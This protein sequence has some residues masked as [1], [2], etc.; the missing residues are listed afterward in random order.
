[1]TEQAGDGSVALKPLILV[2][3]V[4]TLA[5]TLLRL[6]GEVLEWSPQF[7]SREAGGAMAIVGIVWLVP[8]FGA[9]F[10]VKLVQMGHGPSGIGRVFGWAVLGLL[11]F[12]GAGFLGRILPFAQGGRRFILLF[13]VGSIA[14]VW[15]AFRG[16]PALGR[17]LVAYGLAARVPVAVVMLVT[18]LAN[19]GTHYEKGPPGFPE[20]GALAKWF[21]IGLVPQLTL[22]MAF[23]VIVGAL[24]G[25]VAAAVTGRRPKTA[26]A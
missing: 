15:V 4:I 12:V 5:I 17:V 18:I 22:W 2:P 7:F 11:L 26:A 14:A 13:A 9:Y 8:V 21:W 23:T 19:W 1:M 20:M 24:F 16:W 3:A 25:G 10:A 6:T